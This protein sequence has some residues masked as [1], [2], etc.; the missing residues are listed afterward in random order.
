MRITQRGGGEPGDE[1]NN[2]LHVQPP[3]PGVWEGS[4]MCYLS[5]QFNERQSQYYYKLLIPKALMYL[6]NDNLLVKSLT[7]NLEHLVNICIN[8]WLQGCKEIIA[9]NV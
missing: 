9:T 5:T 1:A 2:L 8:N 3:A 6:Q 4:T 7:H